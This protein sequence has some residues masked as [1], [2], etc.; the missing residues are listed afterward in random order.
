MR[1][2]GKS[3]GKSFHTFLLQ[4]HLYLFISR[5]LI[6]HAQQRTRLTP[7]RKRTYSPHASP[8]LDYS[9]FSLFIFCG[10]FCIISHFIELSNPY[11]WSFRKWI[12]LVR[13]FSLLDCF[14]DF[15]STGLDKRWTGYFY[16]HR[17]SSYWHWSDF[18]TCAFCE[19]MF[20]RSS[21]RSQRTYSWH[22]SDNIWFRRSPYSYSQR[23]FQYGH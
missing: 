21:P 4:R 11:H 23:D 19:R 16:Y 5:N 6:S 15:Y 7:K 20:S 18:R 3:L 8:T 10:T 2:I 22:I 17:F 9:Y 14:S 13:N 12:V 1:K